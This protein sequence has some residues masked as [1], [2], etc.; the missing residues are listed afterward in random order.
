MIGTDSHNTVTLI[1]DS[2]TNINIS[3]V[4]LDLTCAPPQSTKPPRLF[5]QPTKTSSTDPVSRPVVPPEVVVSSSQG[6]GPVVS[7]VKKQP[8]PVIP[9]RPQ[10]GDI[11]TE[12]KMEV[13]QGPAGVR[14]VTAGLSGQLPGAGPVQIPIGRGTTVI[15]RGEDQSSVSSGV[16]SQ[17]SGVRSDVPRSLQ[18]ADSQLLNR[19]SD[20]VIRPAQDTII[21]DE[22]S[23]APEAL[24][25]DVIVKE[26]YKETNS[27]VIRW[28]SETDNILG[29]RVIYR[30][31]GTPQFKQGPPLAPSEREFKIKNVP[32]NE[33]IVV[34]VVSLEE[35]EIT[36]SSVPFDQC[37]EIR[38]E[39]VGAGG[40]GFDASSV[41]IPAAA[42][43]VVAVI[44]AVI[45]FI[46]CLK[47]GNKKSKVLGHDKPIHTL[48]MSMNGL[49]TLQGP[50]A[51]LG[52][53]LAGLASLGL[54]PSTKDWDT[55]SMYSQ[56]SAAGANRAR[57]YHIDP[58]NPGTYH[59]HH[60]LHNILTRL[61]F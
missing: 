43:I 32:D 13:G 37:R 31:F 6:Q 59:H 46:M 8:R 11:V 5:I 55:M 50:A 40:K 60:L 21:H 23:I 16:R 28:E 44:V 48:S 19:P 3:N 9:R 22:D 34:C 25:E 7:P 42:A 57:M 26:A 4:I 24:V 10:S 20:L 47:L 45:I 41:I 36:P 38:T 15:N 18:A 27:I 58:R 2:E 39:G 1:I 61:I 49:N 12:L 29:F 14:T 35:V 53:P 17:D 54:G 56:K 30:L 33:C 52:A 51:P